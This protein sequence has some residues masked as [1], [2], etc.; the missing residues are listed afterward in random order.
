MYS[1]FGKHCTNFKR[2]FPAESAY[3]H[4]F[5]Y[6]YLITEALKFESGISLAQPVDVQLV[7]GSPFSSTNMIPVVS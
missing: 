2:V 5:P 7:V 1:I 3:F 6:V 4:H